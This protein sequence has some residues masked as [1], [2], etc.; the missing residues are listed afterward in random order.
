MRIV[1]TESQLSCNSVANIAIDNIYVFCISKDVA[2]YRFS[3]RLIICL[4]RTS[5]NFPDMIDVTRE[6][7]T[8]HAQF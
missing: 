5:M 2:H 6:K 8:S 7:K 3:I 1:W 4:F